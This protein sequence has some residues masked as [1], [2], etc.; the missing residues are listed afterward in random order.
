MFNYNSL[1]M[2]TTFTKWVILLG[3][4]T[5]NM[6]MG[7]STFTSDEYFKKTID[8][9]TEY[10]EDIAR[11][12]VNNEEAIFNSK[13][14]NQMFASEITSFATG[15][16]DQSLEKYF[17]NTNTDNKTLSIGR[18]IDFRELKFKKKDEVKL[19]KMA[20]IFTI[21]AQAGIDKGFSNIYEKNKTTNEYD[22]SNNLGIGF[23]Y[24]HF[25]NGFIRFNKNSREKITKVNNLIIDNY[26]RDNIGVKNAD[27]TFTLAKPLAT[28]VDFI[29]KTETTDK[30]LNLSKLAKKKYFDTYSGILNKQIETIKRDKLYCSY[31]AFWV[32][33]EFYQPVTDK[34]VSSTTD[35]T[36]IDKNK[37]RDW[38]FE[39]FGNVLRNWSSG[40][41]FKFKGTLTRFNTTEFALSNASPITV[42]DITT[43][44]DNTVI[45][46][47]TFNPFFG[48]YKELDVSTV[49]LEA[50]FLF[51]NN[52][53]GISGG[54]EKFLDYNILNWKLGVPFSL[55]DK[56]NKPT[57]NFEVVWRE[58]NKNHVVGINAVYSFGK[59]LK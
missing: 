26:I 12:Q 43:L 15:I 14:L 45:V 37:F 7:Q 50:A 28:E 4:I 19:Q 42:Q 33:A 10:T 40:N 9:K 58:L 41:A 57:V 59:F 27:G 3:V 23:R 49:R 46:N 36:T 21:Y 8:I 47:N 13:F 5:S 34:I 44:N 54:Y 52:S 55:K 1:S 2:K 20:D 39:V 31:T 29:E 51:L 18:S 25:F 17:I 48:E 24:T 11:L 38:R 22:W 32:G 53:I 6:A 16:K 56:D 30:E 35:R